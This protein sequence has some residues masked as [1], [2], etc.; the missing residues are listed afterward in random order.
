MC[1]AKFACAMSEI[2][3]VAPQQYSAVCVRDGGCLSVSG[4]T[5]RAA[6]W[7]RWIWVHR[8]HTRYFLVYCVTAGQRLDVGQM[9][10]KKCAT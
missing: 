7:V 3:P 2:T 9:L 5:V 4:E 6:S 10:L 1:Y 8:Y